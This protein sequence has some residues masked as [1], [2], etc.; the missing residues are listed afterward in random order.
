[1]YTKMLTPFFGREEEANAALTKIEV[2]PEPSKRKPAA[3][4]APSSR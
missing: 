3:E 2:A 1:L 4:V